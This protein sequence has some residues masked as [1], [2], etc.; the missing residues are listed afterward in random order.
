[1][2]HRLVL[3]VDQ[4]TQNEMIGGD[5]WVEKG[6]LGEGDED[7]SKS[8]KKERKQ[9]KSKGRKRLPGVPPP[10]DVMIVDTDRWFR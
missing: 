10:F 7:G 2:C 9:T 5:G 4:A 6:E 8:P 1:M 3:V